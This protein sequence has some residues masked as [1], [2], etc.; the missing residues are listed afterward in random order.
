MKQRQYLQAKICFE[1][2]LRKIRSN[3]WIKKL[4]YFKWGIYTWEI[5]AMTL[6]NIGSISLELNDLE[7]AVQ[8]FDAAIARDPQFPLP[9]ANLAIVNYVRGNSDQGVQLLNHSH[10]LG[11]SLLDEQS[12]QKEAMTIRA[13]LN[14]KEQN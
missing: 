14:A 3:P 13:R 2:F 8:S 10:L 6:N 9:F 5:E 4:I 12:A 1:N 7:G 11:C